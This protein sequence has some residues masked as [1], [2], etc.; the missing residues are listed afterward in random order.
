MIQR[1]PTH[2]TDT[3]A[4]RTILSDLPGEWLVRNLDERDYGIDL[5]IEMFE[6]DK[7]TGKIAL[8]QVKGRD[9]SFP[10]CIAIP[11]PVK[12]IE[13]SLLFSEP[14]FL[15]HTSIKDKQTYFIWIQKYVTSRLD[16]ENSSWRSQEHVTLHFPLE[17]SLR[18]G[19]GK[20]EQIM[21]RYA[22]RSQALEYLSAYDW[23]EDHWD[24]FRLGERDLIEPCLRNL[25]LMQKCGRFLTVYAEFAE[26]KPDFTEAKNCLEA[27]ADAM[28]RLDLDDPSIASLAA[29]F[30]RH[31]HQLRFLKK[32]FLDENENDK[33]AVEFDNPPY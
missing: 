9:A 5:T 7:P 12:T 29:D 26:F 17:N 14:F 1:G 19:R 20:I 23:L 3:L 2:V 8:I 33:V 10:E 30:D 27:I 25:A 16:V 32:S 28:N 13:Y 22:A 11:F 15:F 21:A 24:N 18:A 6:D 4:V 31:L